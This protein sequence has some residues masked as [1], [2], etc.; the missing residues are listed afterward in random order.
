LTGHFGSCID[1]QTRNTGLSK[2]M[3]LLPSCNNF[4]EK[5]DV[6]MGCVLQFIQFLH[7]PLEDFNVCTVGSPANKL[8]GTR[9][10]SLRISRVNATI[11]VIIFSRR[12]RI[13]LGTSLRKR[14]LFFYI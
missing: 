8:G 3:N 12:L 2:I 6:E 4:Y 14:G 9:F 5:R 11:V 10:R 13:D 1:S 7:V